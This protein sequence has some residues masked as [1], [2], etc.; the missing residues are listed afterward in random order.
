MCRFSFSTFSALLSAGPISQK[1]KGDGKCDFHPS[2]TLV[3][4]LAKLQSLLKTG[5]EFFFYQPGKGYY[6]IT[7]LT[8]VRSDI[9]VSGLKLVKASTRG[10]LWQSPTEG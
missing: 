3:S 1:K 8:F 10:Q 2:T 4:Q 5:N 6:D 7:E 9:S